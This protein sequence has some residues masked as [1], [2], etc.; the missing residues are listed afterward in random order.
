MPGVRLSENSHSSIV[1]HRYEWEP[2]IWDPQAASETLR[3]VFS[4]PPGSLPS[5]LS[6]EEEG[7]KLVGTPT[8]HSEPFVVTA[9]AQVGSAKYPGK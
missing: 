9:I 1:N 4:S 8:E 5:W 6:W 2:K 7:T 3:P